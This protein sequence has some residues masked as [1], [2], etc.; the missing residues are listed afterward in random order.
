MRCSPSSR[1]TVAESLYKF[2]RRGSVGPFSG[3]VWRIGEWVAAEGRL[4]ACRNGVH[5][6][7]PG[8]LPYWLADELW[9]VEV[10]GEQIEHDQKLVVRRARI[11]AGAQS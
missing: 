7:R 2:L 1:P 5:V 6:C 8:D 9:Q 3:R 11:R 10:E 4:E